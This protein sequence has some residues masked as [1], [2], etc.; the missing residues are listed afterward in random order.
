MR[1]ERSDIARAVSVLS[2]RHD[3]ALAA[4]VS[5]TTTTIVRFPGPCRRQGRVDFQG[6]CRPGS[7]LRDSDCSRT[8]RGRKKPGCCRRRPVRVISRK[9]GY[10][11]RRA[12]TFAAARGRSRDEMRGTRRD[13]RR[14]TNPRCPGKPDRPTSSRSHTWRISCLANLSQS[15]ASRCTQA[16]RQCGLPALDFIGPMAADSLL[17]DRDC[18]CI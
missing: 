8:R 14:G 11:K 4:W 10:G 1:R 12:G 7:G 5:P 15:L 6:Q 3:D 16:G 13:I 9:N 2:S 17:P 18:S